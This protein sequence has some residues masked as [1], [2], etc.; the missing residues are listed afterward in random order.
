MAASVAALVAGHRRES[1]TMIAITKPVASACFV[2]IAIA[3]WSSPDPRAGWIITALALGALGDVL[4]LGDR[5]FDLGLAAF[6]L[7][8]LSYV[9]AFDLARPMGEWSM[10]IGAA[11][12]AVGLGVLV[13]LWPHLGRRRLPVALYVAAIVTMVWGALAAATAGALPARASCGATLFM[14]SDITVA[15]QR[16][17]CPAFTNRALGLPAYYAGQLLLALS[18]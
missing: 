10:L 16:F 13:W 3:R 6:L 7:G 17:V 11:P 9:R 12:T 8:H 1:F 15:R 18:V 14:L 2:A 5:T 4:L